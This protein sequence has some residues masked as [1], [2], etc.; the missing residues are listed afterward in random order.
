MPSLKEVRTRIDSVKSTQQIT[1]AMKMVS[2]AKL[3]KAQ[4]AILTMRPFA[5]RLTDIMQNISASMDDSAESVY[6]K[7]RAPERVLI[8]ALASNRGLCGP[9]NAN[10]AKEV[11]VRINTVY[12]PQYQAGKLDVLTIGK[13]LN[14]FL[15]ARK[16]AV[17]RRKDEILDDLTF[18]NV[19]PFAESLMNDFV[20]KKYDKIE[21]IYNQFKNAAVQIL[22]RE[23]FLPIAPKADAKTTSKKVKADYIFQPSKEEIIAE[24]IPKSLKIQLYKA[25]LDS[26]ASEQGARMTAMHKATDN[27]QELLKNLKLSYNKARQAAITNEILEIVSGAEALR[28]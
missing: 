14:D 7:Q 5:A 13:K 4:N 28:G 18:E 26:V 24:L 23:Q 11:I 22:T 19:I 3:R 20:S 17:A 1:S 9:F 15:K 8:I 25:L 27:A 12:A 21:I 10:V 2:A 16:Y 6:T